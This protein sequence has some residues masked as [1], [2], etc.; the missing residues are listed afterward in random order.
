[1][2]RFF[3]STLYRRARGRFVTHIE[4]LGWAQ[5]EAGAAPALTAVAPRPELTP[6]E[7]PGTYAQI[8]E[9]DAQVVP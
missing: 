6:R 2:E 9:Q 3:D 8:W 4:N 7:S 1:M 5:G